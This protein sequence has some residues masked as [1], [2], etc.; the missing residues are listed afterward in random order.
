M[1]R[2]TVTIAAIGIAIGCAGTVLVSGLH[3]SHQDSRRV[4]AE[5]VRGL[6]L[7]GDLQY[8]AQEARPSPLAASAI[9][10][11]KL[12][13]ESA[14]RFRAAEAE[15]SARLAE[16]RKL[17]K[18]DQEIAAGEK[19]AADWQV[20]LS[21][22]DGSTAPVATED[23]MA[24]AFNTLRTDLEAARQLLNDNAGKL[25]GQAEASSQESLLRMAL[26]LSTLAAL[27]GLGAVMAHL[28]AMRRELQV[29]EAR[30]NEDF[31]K[32][33]RDECDAAERLAAVLRAV[34]EY[35]IIGM[36]PEGVITVFNH[37]AERMLGYRSEE[38]IGKLVPDVFHDAGEIAARA[39]EL[40]IKPGFEVFV[41]TARRG[42]AETREWTYVRKDGTRLPVSLTMTAKHDSAGKLA[43]FIGVAA[44]ISA[45]QRADDELREL[46]AKLI[47]ASRHAGMAEVAK[48]VLHN[49]GNVLNSVNVSASVIG[50]TVRTSRIG[51]LGEVV[52][53]LRAQNGGLVE[54]LTTDPRGRLVPDLLGRLADGL[55]SEHATLSAETG[56]LTTHVGQIREIVA[57]HQG[58]VTGHRFTDRLAVV[59]LMEEALKLQSASLAGHGIKI[60]REFGNVPPVIADRHKTLEIFTNLIRNAEHAMLANGG[61]ASRLTLT[62]ARSDDNRVRIGV[63]DNGAGILPENLTRIF[64]HDFSTK[65]DGHGFGLHSSALAAQEM[66]GTLTAHSD[67]PGTGATFTLELP[68]ADEPSTVEQRLPI[69]ELA[70]P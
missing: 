25:L 3:R 44:N 31:E 19:I 5:A 65:K 38:V 34:T 41:A 32:A 46:N 15:F 70:T 53:L 6:V 55:R 62:I 58:L 57:M 1:S 35:S 47:E 23:P 11:K 63:C 36:T 56:S 33:R 20:F 67:G 69:P 2:F 8:Q 16:F 24:V 28:R 12:Q 39:A 21:S 40:G 7:I 10:D 51:G 22:R 54:F 45:R 68:L 43:G 50:E 49:V 60:V 4:S 26:I 59:E 37:G 29:A 14:G 9:A 48:G 30:L 18:G 61:R 27:G 42:E 66:G 17:A 64:G 52:A 13:V